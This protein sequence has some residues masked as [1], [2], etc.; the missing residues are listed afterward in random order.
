MLRTIPA[1]LKNGRGITSL[2]VFLVHF[3]WPALPSVTYGTIRLPL[4]L[5]TTTKIKKTLLGAHFEGCKG[6]FL[7]KGHLS[8]VKNQASKL[9]PH[10]SALSQKMIS[11]FAKCFSYAISQN[12][13]N[14]DALKGSLNC[15]VPHAFGDH[16]SCDM[17]W[18]G[19]KK[20]PLTYK[21]N[22]LPHGKDL[23]GEPLKN[24]LRVI[25]C[26]IKGSRS[27]YP[28]D[29]AEILHAVL[30]WGPNYETDVSKFWKI[31]FWEFRTQPVS[32]GSEGQPIWRI[33]GLLVILPS[34]SP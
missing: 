7:S 8:A 30:L 22:D 15:I 23:L 28:T 11:Y 2:H 14:P 32:V 1:K 19:Y 31:L 9:Y 16:R 24:I 12:T 6:R 3:T 33:K 26:I 13:G 10:C 4:I 27:P 17:S 21:H 5:L 20:S 29:L 18:C 25:L 34:S